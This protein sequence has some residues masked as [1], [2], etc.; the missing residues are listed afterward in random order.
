MIPT[1]KT[2]PI[3]TPAPGHPSGQDIGK[4]TQKT[5]RFC[6]SKPY[7]KVS[8]LSCARKL[9]PG[10]GAKRWPSGNGSH[11]NEPDGAGGAMLDQEQQ[12]AKPEALDHRWPLGKLAIQGHE[13]LTQ[14]HQWL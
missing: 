14:I 5:G 1:T 8:K 2:I 7:S 10:G 12:E 6:F 11:N 9:G 13:T 3:P 4:E